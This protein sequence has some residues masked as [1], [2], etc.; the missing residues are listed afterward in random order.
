M[1]HNAQKRENTLLKERALDRGN[2]A[3]ISKD[4]LI[5]IYKALFKATLK[6]VE[7]PI[8]KEILKFHKIHFQYLVTIMADVEN[9]EPIETE[10]EAMT[11]NLDEYVRQTQEVL[12]SLKQIPRTPLDNMNPMDI[13]VNSKDPVFARQYDQVIDQYV[14]LTKAALTAVS[15][16]VEQGRSME[17]DT[18]IMTAQL[19]E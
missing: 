9:M 12:D 6:L 11:K 5:T 2:K 16:C 14:E 18:R 13:M 17:Q 10:I 1:D 15:N 8:A 3:S 4:H 19:L 7:I